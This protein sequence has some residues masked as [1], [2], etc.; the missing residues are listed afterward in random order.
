MKMPALLD[1]ALRRLKGAIKA[2]GLKETVLR[3]SYR[4]GL[5]PGLDEAT[6]RRLVREL[7][8]G[9]VERCSFRRMSGWK[10]SGAY[11]LL[12]RTA[13]G[14]KL[15]LVY[16]RARY[17]SD[18]IPALAGLPVTPGL[19]EYVFFRHALGELGDFLPRVWFAEQSDKGREYRYVM[20]DLTQDYRGLAGPDDRTSLCRVLPDVHASFR[21]I[22]GH[23]DTRPL[24]RFDREFA[25]RLLPY[26][27]RSLEAN[28]TAEAA[29]AVGALLDAW[30]EFS[31]KVLAAADAVHRSE[32]LILIHGDCNIT[33]AMRHR[34]TGAFRILDLEWAGW[35]LP[36][37]DLVSALKGAP[38]HLAERCLGE[39]SRR[40]GEDR[41][42]HDRNIY[43]Y[44][45]ILRAILDAGFIGNQILD[46]R[47]RAPKWFP[48]LIDESCTRALQLSR[49]IDVGRI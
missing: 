39:F 49:S 33:N 11:R 31:M 44:C 3:L 45:A 13:K 41:L 34:T 17:E 43:R 8:D 24:L 21:R 1:P 40:L 14:R 16:K 9:E 26:S 19:G 42:E 15:S 32:P 25:E 36:H 10:Q 46:A 30:P 20:E 27:R 12:T 6:L 35:G 47:A 23:P 22:A 4:R 29:P 48:R 28:R 5:P 7:A 37:Q 38:D 2:M 18:E